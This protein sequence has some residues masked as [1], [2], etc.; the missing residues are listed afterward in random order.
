MTQEDLVLQAQAA[1]RA[2][3]RDDFNR[4]QQELLAIF[5][6]DYRGKTDFVKRFF[7]SQWFLDVGRKELNRL[8]NEILN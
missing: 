1:I 3:R 6:G 5:G 8:V 4:C 2:G 7:R